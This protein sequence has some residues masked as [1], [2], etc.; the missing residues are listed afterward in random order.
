MKCRDPAGLDAGLGDIGNSLFSK[1]MKVMINELFW[2]IYRSPLR[3]VL[4]WILI[5][6]GL[7]TVLSAAF[8]IRNKSAVVWQLINTVL[9]V[10]GLA[11]MIRLTLFERSVSDRGV[12]LMPFR[13]FFAARVHRELYR[14]KLMNVF[15]YVPLG[16]TMP[17][18]VR[19]IAECRGKKEEE[20]PGRDGWI[21]VVSLMAVSVM[22]EFL[23]WLFSVGLAET[24][25]VIANTLGSLIGA[26]SY[27]ISR[28]ILR[29][30]VKQDERFR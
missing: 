7:W 9:F 14:E 6:T 20:D 21:P 2:Q 12:E 29:T 5:L 18:F 8:G 22:V 13:L 15:L 28:R 30:I 24:D 27:F 19:T 17:Y 23:Q 16:L 26:L 4:C 10:L 1:K 11:L 25:D 3:S